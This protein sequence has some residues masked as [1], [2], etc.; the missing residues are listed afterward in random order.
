ML[1]GVENMLLSLILKKTTA[2]NHLERIGLNVSVRVYAIKQ[3]II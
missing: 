2:E 3:M 1:S